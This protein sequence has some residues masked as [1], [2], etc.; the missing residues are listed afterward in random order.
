[1]TVMFVFLNAWNEFLF[2]V[3]L[4]GKTVQTV[5]VHMFNF[6]GMEQTQWARL[7]AA[8]DRRDGPRH[9]ARHRRPAPHREGAD[10]RRGQGRRPAMS[11]VGSVSLRDIVRTH[12]PV[13]A[14]QSLDLDIEPGEFFALLG[15]SGSGKTTT[16]RIVAGLEPA[17]RGTVASTAGT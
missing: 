6:V 10:D 1:M 5:T 7:S 17:D 8:A 16:L 3:L 13:V 14:L 11:A 12:G 15:P 2:A 4:G 9:P